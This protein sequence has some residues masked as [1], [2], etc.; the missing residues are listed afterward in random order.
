MHYSFEKSSCGKAVYRNNVYEK[1]LSGDIV[2]SPFAMW[3]LKL[4]LN[5]TKPVNS[6]DSLSKFSNKV[7]LVLEGNGSFVNAGSTNYDVHKYYQ[8]DDSIKLT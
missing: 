5:E 7:D 6:F 3:K 1:L 2:L 8:V 4:T